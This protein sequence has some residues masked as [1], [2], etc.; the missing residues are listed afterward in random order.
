MYWEQVSVKLVVVL[1]QN[2]LEQHTGCV[3]VLGKYVQLLLVLYKSEILCE[4]HKQF[5]F[6]LTPQISSLNGF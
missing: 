2:M 5:D 1:E 6:P 4:K 3:C